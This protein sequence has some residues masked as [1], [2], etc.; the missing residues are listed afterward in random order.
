VAYEVPSLEQ[1]LLSYCLLHNLK[2]NPGMLDN[3]TELNVQKWFL[4]TEDYLNQL[5]NSFG[6][7]QNAQPFGTANIKIARVDEAVRNSISLANQKPMVIAANVLND[8]TFDDD[9]EL[10]RLIN[11]S[12]SDLSQ[13]GVDTKL[14]YPRIETPETNRINI[15]YEVMQEKYVACDIRLIKK[16]EVLYRKTRWKTSP[17]ILFRRWFLMRSDREILV[18]L[19]LLELVNKKFCVHF[20]Q[21]LDR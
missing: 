19:S 16:G 2:N 3:E 10:K 6:L 9:L 12:L 21:Y 17:K 8:L 14:V 1:G 18:S 5:V 11:Q 20:D 13:R 4:E 7:S 15:R